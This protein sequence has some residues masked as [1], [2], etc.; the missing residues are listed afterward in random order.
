MKNSLSQSY[1]QASQFPI[2][3]YIKVDMHFTLDFEPQ[4]GDT[5]THKKKLQ[6]Q[7]YYLND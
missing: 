7:A 6:I 2:L 1:T 4:N 3:N 5:H